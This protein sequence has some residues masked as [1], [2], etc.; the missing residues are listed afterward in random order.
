MKSGAS[1]SSSWNEKVSQLF[2][3]E[4]GRNWQTLTLHRINLAHTNHKQWQQGSF[5]YGLY[6]WIFLLHQWKFN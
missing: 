5:F 6:W 1:E 4:E 3:L 2:F